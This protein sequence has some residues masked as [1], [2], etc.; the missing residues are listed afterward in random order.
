MSVSISR[1]TLCGVYA[2]IAVVAL[3]GTWLQNVKYLQMHLGF[4]GFQRIFYQDSLVNPAG[5]AN[6]VDLYFFGVAVFIWMVMEARRLRMRAIWLYPLLF[7]LI[8][9]SVFVPV[10]LINRQ[11]ALAAQEGGTIAGAMTKV[12]AA[13]LIVFVLAVV[14]LAVALLNMTWH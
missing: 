14:A 10:F 3:A 9:I 2:F 1:K 7:L 6:F 5:R 12:D 4:W 11:R 13:G 8:G